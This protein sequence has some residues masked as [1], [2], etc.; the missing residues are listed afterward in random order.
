MERLF[1]AFFYSLDGFAAAWKDEPAFR[2]ELYALIPLIPLGIWL[3]PDKIALI[4]MLS[5]MLLVLIAELINSAIEAVTD[6]T[7]M[8]IHPLAKKA[9]DTASAAVLLSIVNV[10]FVWGI[11][12]F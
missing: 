11:L 7:G 12:L 6:K 5:S 9:K 2:Q 1:K 3:A 4:L 8:D 10:V